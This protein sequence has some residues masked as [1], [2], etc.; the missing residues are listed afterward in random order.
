MTR[1]TAREEQTKGETDGRE[2]ERISSKTHRSREMKECS[3]FAAMK[4]EI[5]PTADVASCWPVVPTEHR[6][7]GHE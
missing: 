6:P 4:P 1:C 5:G 3:R 2:N 7:L